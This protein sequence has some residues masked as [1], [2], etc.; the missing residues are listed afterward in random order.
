MSKI[1]LY[2]TMVPWWV[3][4]LAPL[5]GVIAAFGTPRRFR[6][7]VALALVPPW[8]TLGQLVGLGSLA[9][10]AK[11]TEF[12]LYLLVAVAAI[13]DAGPKRKLPATAYGY[14]A[15]GFLGFAYIWTVVDLDLAAAIRIQWILLILASLMVARTVVD[16]ASLM[17]V[18]RA[19]M[20]GCGIALLLP[21]SNLVMNPGAAFKATGRFSPYEVNSNHVGVLFALSMPLALYMAY[22]KGE[23]W[24]WK[25]ACSGAA[26]LALM[27]GLITASRSTMAV[28]IG[29]SG[30]VALAFSRRPIVM[31][32]AGAAILGGLAFALTFSDYVNFSRMGSIE[33]PGRDL[34]HDL[35][36][37]LFTERPLFGLLGTEGESFLK[38][39]TIDTAHAHNAYLQQ[40]YLGG[41]SYGIPLFGIALLTIWS[42]AVSWFGR[43]RFAM[44]PIAM[45][46]LAAIMA[47]TYAHGMVNSSMY[48]PTTVISFTHILFSVLFLSWAMDLKRPSSVTGSYFVEH[49]GHVP[50]EVEEPE[51]RAT[52]TEG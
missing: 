26:V 33:T 20:F 15:V 47:M 46:V 21:F 24:W 31:M 42:T 36:A 17:R 11:V 44:D 12:A 38:L 10:L 9:A 22:R 34:Q 19:L 40:L 50:I 49:E 48:Y 35:Y 13:A 14:V 41:L 6:L 3:I 25:L 30:P 51:Y 18:L 5:I 16:E 52:G 45:S 1:E 32:L 29:S 8:L 39:E 43:R 7:P 23:A 37:E 4:V 27:M 2:L 28:M